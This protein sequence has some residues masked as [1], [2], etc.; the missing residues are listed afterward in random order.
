MLSLTVRENQTV[1]IGP[2]AVKVLCAGHRRLRLAITAPKEIPITRLDEYG[3][4][5][6]PQKN[7]IIEIPV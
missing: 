3:Q 6:A 7:P 5:I 2:I 1:Q 4:V